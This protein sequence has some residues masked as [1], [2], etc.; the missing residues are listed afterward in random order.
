MQTNEATTNEATTPVR[1]SRRW[2]YTEDHHNI[3]VIGSRVEVR[4]DCATKGQHGK[5]VE[6]TPNR[7]GVLLDGGSMMRRYAPLR[8]V[9][10]FNWR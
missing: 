10:R 8:F 6:L 4:S 2:A 7:V 1:C 5:V 3:L 9:T